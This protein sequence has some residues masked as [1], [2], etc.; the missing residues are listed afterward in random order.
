[1]ETEIN[2]A[3]VTWVLISAALVM[4]MPPGLALFYGGLARS[5]NI[6]GTIIHSFMMLG[7]VSI[8]FVKVR[9]QWTKLK[10]LSVRSGSFESR[11]LCPRRA[12]SD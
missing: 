3:D 4:L 6:L 12:L 10:R 1:M 11:R 8:Q 2:G 7:V 9:F 5:K